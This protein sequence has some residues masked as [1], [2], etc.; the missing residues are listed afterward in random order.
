VN[1]KVLIAAAVVSAVVGLGCVA[2]SWRRLSATFDEPNHLSTGLEWLQQGSY[3]LWTENPPLA[4]VVVAAVPYMAGA[5]LPP[6]RTSS[7]GAPIHV[8]SWNLGTDVLYREG[9][10][11]RN[12]AQARAGTAV[13]F[14][15]TV[16][17]TWLLA[18]RSAG[19]MAGALAAVMVATL[20]PML[21][22]SGL[23]TTDVGFVAMFLLAVWTFVRWLERPSLQRSA[24]LGGAV[25]LVVLTKFTALLFFPIT[26][27]ALALGHLR[28][29]RDLR[30]GAARPSR[31]DWLRGAALAAGLAV[32]LG[33]AG[34][35]FSFGPVADPR[36]IS[37]T[38][39]YEIL[40]PKGQRTGLQALLGDRTLPA[41]EF[42]YGLLHLT[43]HNAV[44][45]P[46]YLRGQLGNTGFFTFYPVA[47]F[48]KAPLPFLLLVAA[49]LAALLADARKPGTARDLALVAATLGILL[50]L[51]TS[52]IN[53]GVRHALVVYPLWAISAAVGLVRLGDRLQQRQ[54]WLAGAAVGGL[55]L[56]QQAT[57]IAARHDYLSYF[58]L[59]AGDEP[60]QILL[61][62]DLDWGQ[63][64]LA[65]ADQ[66]RQRQI[67]ALKIGLRMSGT[68]NC[69]HG[70]PPLEPLQPHQPAT[71]WVAVTE[72]LYWGRT[73]NWLLRDPCEPFSRW[74]AA[75]NGQPPGWFR[76][77][78]AFQPVW[79]GAGMR[80]YNIRQP[81]PAATR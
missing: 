1:K 78:H 62:S 59:L 47:L 65:L 76:W 23:A 9:A 34:Y 3:T 74:G 80:L 61:D 42:F 24:V 21:A 31:R 38:S 29:A 70:L 14:L 30:A 19:P 81:V 36:F 16:L 48:Y 32:L 11:L 73:E 17:L 45:H 52:R 2:A 35:R 43:G 72:N 49:G 63:G 25:A 15:L 40:A 75:G 39:F 56:A 60:G 27:V 6:P 7:D 37:K 69:E 71:G 64:V 10:Y 20:P 67:A 22:H 13:F 54:R 41:P 77:L 57:A 53:I 51:T 79:R 58:N 44:G 46:A 4:R 28:A 8:S 66:A 26:A 12:L 33:W 68:R 55:L 50:V 18:A 5:R